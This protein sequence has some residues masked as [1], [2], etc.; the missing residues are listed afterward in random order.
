MK[1]NSYDPK[2]SF[3]VEV[4][5]SNYFADF[6]IKLT[7]M[8]DL[9]GSECFVKFHRRFLIIVD[10]KRKADDKKEDDANVFDV[11]KSLTNVADAV[12]YKEVKR[13]V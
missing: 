4:R 2:P 5:D 7:E 11:I 12:A 3:N 6:H 1:P 13:Q 9:S 8:I 10:V